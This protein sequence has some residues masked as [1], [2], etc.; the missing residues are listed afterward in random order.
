MRVCVSLTLKQHCL[1]G[2]LSGK[3]MPPVKFAFRPIPKVEPEK[4]E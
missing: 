4:K 3:D 1:E 2:T